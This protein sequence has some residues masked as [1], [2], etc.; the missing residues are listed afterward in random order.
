MSR[1]GAGRKRRKGL[2]PSVIMNSR[3]Q[4]ETKDK[5]DATADA[6]GITLGRYVQMLVDRDQLDEYGRPLW[7]A[8][9]FPDL[10]DP[11]PGLERRHAA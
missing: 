5:A 2:P 6:L 3:V 10:A 11:I 4:Q 8:E 7:A 9:V 1:G